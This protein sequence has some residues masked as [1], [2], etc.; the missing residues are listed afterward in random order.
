MRQRQEFIT[1]RLIDPGHINR[2]DLM[3]EFEIT[4]QTASM[5]LK[6]YKAGHSQM[7]YDASRKTFRLRDDGA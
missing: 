1:M 5:D 2:A 3:T 4:Y 7:V 6:I